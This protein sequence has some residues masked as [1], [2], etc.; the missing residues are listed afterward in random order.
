MPHA[1]IENGKWVVVHNGQRQEFANID[2]A[3]AY[4]LSL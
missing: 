1:Y 3:T 4:L 2:R